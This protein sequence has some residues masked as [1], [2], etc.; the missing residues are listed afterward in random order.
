MAGDLEAFDELVCRYR[1]AV[2]AVACQVADLWDDAEDAAPEIFL[3][4]LHCNRRWANEASKTGMGVLGAVAL[5]G[6]CGK[7]VPTQ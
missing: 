4:A 5:S 7:I 1:P 2:L 3:I 6:R